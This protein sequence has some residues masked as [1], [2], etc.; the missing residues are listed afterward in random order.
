[1]PPLGAKI[2][3]LDTS[4]VMDDPYAIHNFMEH[5][6]YIHGAAVLEELDR[7]KTKPGKDFDA[8]AAIRQIETY[9]EKGQVRHGIDKPHGGKFFIDYTIDSDFGLLP[10]GLEHNNDNRMI[11]LA[12]NLQIKFPS[13]QV[14]FVSKDIKPRITANFCGIMSQNYKRDIIEQVYTGMMDIDL[15]GDEDELRILINKAYTDLAIE[16]DIIFA[17]ADLNKT[18]LFPNQCCYFS[19]NGRSS[20]LGIYKKKDG[21]FRI[22]KTDDKIKTAVMPRNSE[23]W[24]AHYLLRDPKVLCTTFMGQ[25]GTGK[26]LIPTAAGDELVSQGKYE[27]M[28]IFRPTQEIGEELGFLPGT[29]DKKFAPWATPI[30][31]AFDIICNFSKQDVRDSGGKASHIR[32]RTERVKQHVDDLISR[33]MLKI[34][35][36]NYLPGCNLRDQFIIVDEAQ[37]FTRKDIKKVVSRPAGESKLVLVGD[38]F[39]VAKD[40]MDAKS[41][42]FVYLIEQYKGLE[43]YAHLT[44]HKKVQRGRLAEMANERL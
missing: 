16:E 20:A 32:T 22:I 43:E 33:G 30:Y 31:D 19:I 1:M 5:D 41:N 21:F 39:Q 13:K 23:Q 38:P 26:T 28:N 10:E 12:R 9:V 15:V 3:V 34:S 27:Q 42:G 29:I 36:I 14:I 11:L 4:V 37:N 24:F 2:F 17:L 8:R 6:V 35:P 25:A 7:L 18:E 44:L 40:H